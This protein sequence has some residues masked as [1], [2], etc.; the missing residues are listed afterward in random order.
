MCVESVFFPLCAFISW[1]L[2][3][4]INALLVFVYFREISCYPLPSL[5]LVFFCLHF[6][7]FF[8]FGFRLSPLLQQWL[9][10]TTAS[11]ESSV[12]LS[13]SGQRLRSFCPGRPSP[14]GSHAA[15]WAS[16]RLSR[17][18]TTSCSTASSEHTRT[19]TILNVK[20][21]LRTKFDLSHQS[22]LYSNRCSCRCYTTGWKSIPSSL[23]SSCCLVCTH[24]G[25]QSPL[26][27]DGCAGERCTRVATKLEVSIKLLAISQAW[28]ME[29]SSSLEQTHLHG[30]LM[31]SWSFSGFL[32]VA[33]YSQIPILTFQEPVNTAVQDN[34]ICSLSVI[35]GLILD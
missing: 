10:I 4:W 27:R 31:W 18:P 15:R 5:S 33:W 17:T 3:T 13:W 26:E 21:S 8:L 16:L 32:Q 23:H 30:L 22:H 19:R 25:S 12:E 29:W 35:L 34:A 14:C 24:R 11:R 20:D 2:D 1:C 6:P 28:F 7:V 9:F